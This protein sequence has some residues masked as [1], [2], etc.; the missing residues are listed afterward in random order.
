M[1]LPTRD[2]AGTI[3]DAV[4]DILAETAPSL[5][6]L[7]VDDGSNDD[8]PARLATVRDPRMTVI[9]TPGL[10]IVAALNL[11]VARARAPLLARMDG[12]DR[13]HPGR[14]GAQRDFLHAHPDVHL[15]GARVRLEPEGAAGEGMR[16]YVEWQNGLL[17]P[18]DHRREIFVESPLCHPSVM[19]RR[20]ALERLGGYRELPWPEDYDLWLRMDAAG[21][22]LAKLDQELL[23]WCHRPGRLTFTH[24]RY[25]RDRIREAKG[26]FLAARLRSLGRPVAVWGAG[27]TGRRIARAMERAGV[28]AALFVDIDPRKVGGRARGAEIAPPEALRRGAYTVVAAVGAQGARGLIRAALCDKGLVEGDDFVVAA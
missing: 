15:V 24:P 7:V 10:G 8:T 13:S 1:L 19:M 27:P 23:S 16:R 14:L 21:M 18:E 6:L 9:R 26:T 20:E 12:D 4:G 17:T 22:K 11:A 2:N 28:R 5:E 25:G 3:L